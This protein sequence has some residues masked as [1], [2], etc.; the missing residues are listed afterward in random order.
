M[1]CKA[2]DTIL[3]DYEVF[4]Y[5][6]EEEKVWNEL[7]LTCRKDQGDWTYTID[8]PLSTYEVRKQ[9]RKDWDGY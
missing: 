7:C 6:V 1:R 9:I 8:V 4:E 5:T 3:K 2:C